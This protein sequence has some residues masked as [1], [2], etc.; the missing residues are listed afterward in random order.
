MTRSHTER[1]FDHALT[2]W[3]KEQT[4]ARPS[5]SDAAILADLRLRLDAKLAATFRAAFPPVMGGAG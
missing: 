4:H 3:V 1:R 5:D 2:E